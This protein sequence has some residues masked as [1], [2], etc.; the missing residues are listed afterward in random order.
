MMGK[1]ADC[2]VP[3]VKR[4]VEDQLGATA[5]RRHERVGPEVA[6]APRGGV[7]RLSEREEPQ[8]VQVTVLGID[9]ALPGSAARTVGRWHPGLVPTLAEECRARQR[10][11]GVRIGLAAERLGDRVEE[12]HQDDGS[13]RRIAC[14]D[15]VGRNSFGWLDERLRPTGDRGEIRRGSRIRQ[16]RSLSLRRSSKHHGQRYRDDQDPWALLNSLASCHRTCPCRDFR[17]GEK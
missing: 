6:V 13:G 5:E 11:P 17:L 2:I 14:T 12:P 8:P 3:D 15:I 10:P 16:R 1:P 9:P 4:N 7:E